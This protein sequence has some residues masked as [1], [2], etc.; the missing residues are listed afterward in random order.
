MSNPIADRTLPNGLRLLALRHG[1]TPLAEVRLHLPAPCPTRLDLAESALL[2]ASLAQLQDAYDGV[3]LSAM[4]DIHRISVSAS[5]SMADLE[6]LL[7]A[8]AQVV[9]GAP[10]ELEVARGQLI[11]Q[12][13]MVRAHPDLAVR[14]ELA[15]HLFGDHPAAFL[16]PAEAEL[17]SIME[18][19]R[20]FDP[21]GAVLVLLT[22]AD[23]EQMADA[24]EKALGGWRPAARSAPP[25]PPLPAIEGGR[26]AL[27]P[28]P[29][30]PQSRI[31]LR[32]QAL[33]PDDDR[34]PAVFLA[35]N[36]LGG[37][38]SSR[39]SRN[40][41]EDKGYVYG[42]TSMFDLH[43]G[44]GFLA[45]EADTAAATTNP[46][47]AAV[48]DE[49]RRMRTHPPTGEEIQAARAFATGSTA[50]RLAPR[51]AFATAIADLAAK[52]IDPLFLLDFS[53]KLAAVTPEAVV[54]AAAE[55]LAPERFAGVIAADP[56]LVTQPILN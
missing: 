28:R 22:S 8:L 42:I 27:L 53:R 35:C 49:L 31:R 38:L 12:F 14:T 23:P 18:L 20:T 19:R 10:I 9:E 30:A 21:R 6:S 32:A 13:R 15:R 26:L 37:Y 5:S 52:A 36:V 50:T 46:A 51:A 29:G 1:S 34:Y 33:T 45:I 40:L 17:A 41:R 39:L 55:F 2:A 3:E 7:A 54:A 47:L 48:G 16:L 56:E 11:A 4:A 43:P 44:S 24:A 25:L